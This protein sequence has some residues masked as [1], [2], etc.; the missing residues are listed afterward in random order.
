MGTFAKSFGESL[1]AKVFLVWALSPKPFS[2]GFGDT[3]NFEY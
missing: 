2:E 3:K 1:S